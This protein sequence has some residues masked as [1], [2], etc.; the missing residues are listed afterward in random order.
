[1]ADDPI[2][3][4]PRLGSGNVTPSRIFDRIRIDALDD[5]DPSS[6]T[7]QTMLT[8]RNSRAA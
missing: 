4:Q 8:G 1:M 6:P 2:C 7:R 5:G 3:R